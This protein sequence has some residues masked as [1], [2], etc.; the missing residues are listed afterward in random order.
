M[1]E[2]THHFA[3]REGL[4]L[5]YTFRVQHSFGTF[6]AFIKQYTL[7]KRCRSRCPRVDMYH[8]AN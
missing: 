1:L 5:M 6:Y 4:F 2:L 8:N 7:E 3:L